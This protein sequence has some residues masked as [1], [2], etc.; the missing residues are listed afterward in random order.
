MKE[1]ILISLIQNIATLLAFTLIYDYSWL[2]KESTTYLRKTISGIIIGAIG[3]LLM[4]TPWTFITGVVF[5]TRSILLSVSGLFFG[6]IPTLIAILI[7]SLFRISLG[8]DGIYMGVTVIVFSGMI[9]IAW[10]YVRPNWKEK[11]HRAELFSMG[12]LVHLMMLVST[13][14]LPQGHTL[15]TLKN[16]TIPVLLLYPAGTM[17]L[18]MLMLKQLQNWKNQKAQDKLLESERRFTE[19]LEDVNLLSQILDTDENITFC[20]DHLL[21]V[22]GYRREEVIG[23]NW[24]DLFLPSSQ[25]DHLRDGFNRIIKEELHQTHLEDQIL[26]KDGKLLTVSWYSV[27][28]RD[29]DKGITGT[30]SIGE[31]ITEKKMAEEEKLKMANILDAS[32]NEIYLSDAKTFKFKY[33]NHGAL[34]NLGYTFEESLQL[35][36]LDITADE[37]KDKFIKTLESWG[38]RNETVSS[39]TFEAKN[40]RADGSTYPVEINIQLFEYPTESYYLAMVQD[41]TK[42]KAI[43]NQLLEAKRKAEESDKLKSIFLANMSHEIRTPLNAIVGFSNLLTDSEPSQQNKEQYTSIINTSSD[44]LLQIINDIIDIS[45]LDAKQMKVKKAECNLYEIVSNSINT[46]QK[47]E[48]LQSKPNI[49]LI[50][51]LRD[52]TKSTLIHTDKNRLQQVL[53]NLISNG[54]KYTEEGFIEVGMKTH[55]S[56]AEIYIKDTGIGI[57]KEKHGIVFERFRQIDEEVFHEGAGIGLSICKGIIDLLGGKISFSSESKKGSTFV[58]EIPL[59]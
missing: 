53:D 49:S 33:M 47:S 31:N 29:S 46:F 51:K 4:I 30:A 3:I 6:A 52:N 13:V 23:K 44:R 17:F 5:D 36:P 35:T 20:N 11:K 12:M 1:S 21:K 57:P 45:K 39:A 34:K 14:L 43:E 40:K 55:E 10:G 56:H 8:G 48:L 2:K 16:I 28:L 15:E 9:G 22:T 7:T 42:R 25:K 38:K 58:I 59:Y 54:I 37:G 50:S 26:T 41:I 24:F 27:I 18:G 19:L 32:Q